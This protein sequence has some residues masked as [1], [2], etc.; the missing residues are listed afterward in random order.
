MGELITQGHSSQ[1]MV[2][3]FGSGLLRSRVA[4]F[5][6]KPRISFKISQRPY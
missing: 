6:Q 4:L 2:L 1:L 5:N 3:G